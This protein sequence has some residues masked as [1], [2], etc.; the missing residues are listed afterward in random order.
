MNIIKIGKTEDIAKV[1]QRI[2]NL[3]E[4]EAVFELEN[5]SVLFVNS[6]NLRL[7]RKTGEVQGKKIMVQTTDPNGRLL[8]RKAEVLYEDEDMKP[9]RSIKPVSRVARSDVRPKFG[10]I[11]GPRKNPISSVKS[12]LPAISIPSVASI[13]KVVPS[14]HA[15]A[16]FKNRSVFSRFFILTMIV[17]VL[18]SFALA[19]LL[20][21]ASIVVFARSETVTRDV[22]ITVDKNAKALNSQ[23]LVV[24]GTVISREVSQTKNY[25][26]TGSKQVGTKATGTL[27]IY[28]F[29]KNTLTLRAGTT[30]LVAD[31]KRF[32]F[33]K[34][35]TN[36]RPTARIGA[37]DEQEVDQSSLTAPVPVTAEVIGESS[38]MAASTKFE[39]RNSALGNNANVYAVNSAA[40][41]G[42][43]IKNITVV[44]QE[45]IDKAT[46]DLTQT[47]AQQAEADLNAENGSSTT[48]KLLPSAVSNEVLARTAGKDPGDES[49]SF[50]MTI[51]A[52]V[53]G[54]T[55]KEEDVTGV[56]LDK[57]NSVLSDDKYLLPEAKNVTDAKYKSIDLALGKGVLS[58]HFETI[59]AYRVN[60]SNVSALL[61]GKNANEIKEILLTRP[62]IDRVDV[63]FSPFFVNKAP[64]YNGKIYIETKLSEQ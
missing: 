34:D 56:M 24:P 30:V 14:I 18:V 39:I 41:A 1:I 38:N 35:A 47:L 48:N 22:E 33:N 31:G 13:G 23:D 20:P 29:T 42:G 3:H 57:I 61:A 11:M 53:T 46:A 6:N 32:V 21:Q 7:I 27:T 49:S 55:Y 19:V 64:R 43:T 51:I 59:A 28:N 62:E 40:L 12:K 25:P 5:G 15:P 10:D 8:A 26:A 9:S 17:L 4:N 54:L 2:K 45:D 16:I 58:V 36:I 63:E 44:S 60:N 52:K 50:D 37:G